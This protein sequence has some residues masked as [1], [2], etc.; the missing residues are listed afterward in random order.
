M[1]HYQIWVWPFGL[2]NAP[3][4]FQIVLETQPTL[5][6]QQAGWSEYLQRL[7]F[8]WAHRPGRTNEAD[9]LSRDPDFKKLYAILAATTS[10]QAQKTTQPATT[11]SESLP[12]SSKS[13]SQTQPETTS[14][15]IHQ[16]PASGADFIGPSVSEMPYEL[17]AKLIIAYKFD[18]YIKVKNN[19]DILRYLDNLWWR[20][21]QVVVPKDDSV[22]W[23]R[24][25]HYHAAPHA[26][27]IGV[28]KTFE[29]IQ[30]TLPM[31]YSAH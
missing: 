2:T 12:H 16:T 14:N 23:L 13:D 9:P 1:S 7:H 31:T 25:Q 18:A 10:R 29:A 4:T 6:R 26:G 8:T 28:T 11:E 20:N 19:T 24:F 15:H 27:H 22:K 21:D 30:Q 5:S 17:F 3:A